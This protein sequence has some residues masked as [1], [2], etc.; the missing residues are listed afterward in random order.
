MSVLT[1]AN[2]LLYTR[3]D[4]LHPRSRPP[5][6]A[7]GAGPRS[8]LH[9]ASVSI[10]KIYRHRSEL[11]STMWLTDFTPDFFEW[12]VPPSRVIMLLLTCRTMRIALKDVKAVVNKTDAT[13]FS[14]GE[15]LLD[16]LNRLDA[17]CKV[18]V[19]RLPHAF[20]REGGALA[21]ADALPLNGDSLIQKD[22]F[23]FSP[24]LMQT[25]GGARHHCV[26]GPALPF[27]RG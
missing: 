16:S 21:L 27:L 1:P 23:F 20:L 19:L 25:H 13:A 9:L 5:L 14:N 8:R 7:H 26:T 10:F 24:P 11:H 4:K 17:L 6:A 12:L 3:E 22:F 2:H 18:S 15:G